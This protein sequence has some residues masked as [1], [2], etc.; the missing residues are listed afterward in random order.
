MEKL[1]ED[2]D[3]SMEAVLQ[4]QLFKQDGSDY[5]KLKDA[6]VEYS[7]H[8]RLYITTELENP[9]YI[10]EIAMVVNLVNFTMTEGGLNDWVTDIGYH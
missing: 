3:P 9:K 7:E 10:P 5:V 6:V 4:K 1:K 8:F 2:F